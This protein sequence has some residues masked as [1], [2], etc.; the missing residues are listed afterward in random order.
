MN[1]SYVKSLWAFLGLDLLVF[2]IIYFGILPSPRLLI[3]GGEIT[4]IAANGKPFQFLV[5]PKNKNYVSLPQISRH[6]RAAVVAL[7]DSRF[8][9]HHGIDPEEILN[10]LERFSRG[11]KLRG[12]STLTQQLAKNLYLTHKRSFFRKFKEALIA[13]KLEQSLPKNK[14]L[15]V[16]LNSI[17]WGRGL[18]GVRQAAMTYFK[19]RPRDLT[20][21]ESVFLA[22][23]IPNPTRFGRLNDNQIPKRFVRRQM[24]R[25][26][27]TMYEQGVISLDQYQTAL[28][29]PV[30]IP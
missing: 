29:S 17:E 6:L 10:A 1:S 24:T 19:K 15:E 23:I 11:G 21:Q 7:E 30:Q 5:G 22:A 2:A 16:Y 28:A 9:E 26:L 12:A 8:Y 27:Q 20:V 13:T 4:R 18:L 3:E 14:I 25:A